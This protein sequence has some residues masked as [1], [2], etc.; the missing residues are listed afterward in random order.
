MTVQSLVHAAA[1]EAPLNFLRPMERR[2][3]AYQYDPPPGVPVRTGDYDPHQIS[4]RDGRPIAGDLSLDVEGFALV[5]A[6]SVFADFGDEQAIR[7]VYYAEVERLI[8]AATG[9]ARVINFDHNIRSA[10][11]A[12]AGD[13]GFRGPAGRTHHDFKSGRASWRE[14]VVRYVSISVVAV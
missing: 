12:A 2:P 5:D 14:R 8:A 4:I 9:A 3:V 6:P 10:A 13:A 1:V 7:S 11:R